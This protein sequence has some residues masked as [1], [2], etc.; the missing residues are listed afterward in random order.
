M[1]D[2]LAASDPEV[3]QYGPGS[4]NNGFTNP[5]S[6]RFRF[7]GQDRGDLQ[8]QAPTVHTVGLSA[9]KIFDIGAMQLETTVQFFNLFDAFDHNQFT[10]SSANRTYSPN[11]LQLRSR[12]NARTMLLRTTLRF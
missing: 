9:G 6:T 11:F 2:R 7:V 3:T 4:A 10:Y 12:Q 5:L 8:V 1:L